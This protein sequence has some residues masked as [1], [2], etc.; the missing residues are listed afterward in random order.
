MKGDALSVAAL[1]E[2]ATWHGAP[3][4]KK[5]G[6]QTGNRL[7]RSDTSVKTAI[8][9]APLGLGLLLGD[10][11]D[12]A[13]AV[14]DLIGLDAHTLID[15]LAPH[16]VTIR[17]MAALFS[18]SSAMRC[19]IARQPKCWARLTP[20]ARSWA[21]RAMRCSSEAA[22]SIVRRSSSQPS[23]KPSCLTRAF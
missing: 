15:A 4:R 10:A 5:G 20:T 3:P 12:V 9:Q 22:I 8:W 16:L 13:A 11:V 2:G 18:R 19:M 17:L 21:L 6:S 7:S 14:D 1:A 23:D